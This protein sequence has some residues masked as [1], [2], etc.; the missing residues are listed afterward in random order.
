VPD[1]IP[2][3][4]YRKELLARVEDREL[5]R[6]GLTAEEGFMLSR[7]EK[8]MP[9]EE[10]LLSSG[11]PEERAIKVLKA[12]VAKGAV[13]P[14]GMRKR[15]APAAE[16]VA[17]R[18]RYDGFVFSPADLN[19][20]VDLE[21]GQKKEILWLSGQLDRLSHYALLGVKADADAATVK[22]A[23]L[24][25]SKEFHPDRFFRKRLGSFKDRIE[26]IFKALARANE[27][28]SDPV[29]RI[30]YDT[31][32]Y[33]RFTPEEKA[34]IDRLV[35]DRESE[36]RRRADR[37]RV[38]AHARGFK[39]I[40]AAR[41]TYE[42]GLDY[43]KTGDYSAAAEQFKLVGDLDPRH[44]DAK[45]KLAE[46][47]KQAARKR[48]KDYVARAVTE[49]QAGD[50]TAAEQLYYAALGQ[51]PDYAP[52]AGRLARMML[53]QR[54]DPKMVKTYAEK[55]VAGEPKNADFRVTLGEVLYKLGL[56]KNAKREL[57]MA[58]QLEPNHALA[59]ALLKKIG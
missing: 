20:E 42:R 53:A 9:I 23:F 8:P 17:P 50:E 37:R 14:P 28:L 56:K 36:E 34:A 6:L 27:A 45:K 39:K 49:E 29:R 21:P 41:E 57:E 16:P 52:A 10:I 1:V 5:Q 11:L 59:K 43:M 51:D 38:L 7:I 46:A 40:T 44:E 54:K 4:G 3:L 24:E 12:L 32:H 2:G 33:A 48:A 47:T 35:Q 30:E 15:H 58:L 55:G 31:E 19:E 22:H 25:K 13:A 18:P 26:R